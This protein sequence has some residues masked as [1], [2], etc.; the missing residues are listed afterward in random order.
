LPKSIDEQRKIA[1]VLTQADDAI[2]KTEA[3]I[4]KY[5]TVKTGMMQDLLTRGID[6]HGRIRSEAT[7]KFKDSPLGRIPEE[8]ECVLLST[9][10]DAID[11]QPDH[12]TP[13]AVEEGFP[14]VGISDIDEFGNIS[15]KCRRVGWNVIEKQHKAFQI[16]DGNIIFGKIGT[17][18]KPKLL[19]IIDTP[20]AISANVIV[21]KPH[22]C[23]K[24][25]Y[26]ALNSSYVSK[27]VDMAIHSTSQPAFGMEKIRNLEV[28]KPSIGERNLIAE[29]ITSIDDTIKRE[30][31]ELEKN[32]EL[33][34]GL[35]HDLITGSV[36]V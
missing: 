20:Y 21:I 23:A 34:I 36:R 31:V 10:M 9:L 3:T 35:L 26:Y 4:A 29:I 7:H 28:L 27:E 13:A 8:W 2:S 32:I 18:G 12:R 24:Y 30:T 22:S 1:A 17:I 19:P 25:L 14:Y 6:E 16:E 5:E 15:E 33:S 11:A